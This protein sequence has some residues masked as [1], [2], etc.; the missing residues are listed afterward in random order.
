[1]R[2]KIK[3]GLEISHYDHGVKYKDIEIHDPVTDEY[4]SFHYHTKRSN[5]VSRHNQIREV[6]DLLLE[7]RRKLNAKS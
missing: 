2:Y 5:V 3:H 6:I 7:A 1:M 4:I